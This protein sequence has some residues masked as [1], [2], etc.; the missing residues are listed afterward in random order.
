MASLWSFF[1][2]CLDVPGRRRVCGMM[3]L[4]TKPIFSM[5][6]KPGGGSV[7]WHTSLS[8]DARASHLE[9]EN[10]RW[11]VPSERDRHIFSEQWQFMYKDMI[12]SGWQYAVW[13]TQ[14]NPL[15]FIEFKY[16][17]VV[18]HGVSVTECCTIWHSQEMNTNEVVKD[19]FN[20]KFLHT[21]FTND[22]NSIRVLE[23]F[24]LIKIPK[25]EA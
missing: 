12:R 10:P 4:L 20:Y 15:N 6:I 23:C 9:W 7:N 21:I 5:G 22:L 17:M 18:L 2:T 1:S 8:S 25:M 14:M 24:Q 3:D 13:L 16:Q 11:T 19:A